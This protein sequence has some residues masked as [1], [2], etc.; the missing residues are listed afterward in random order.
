MSAIIDT[1]DTALQRVM[2][3]MKMHIGDYCDLATTEEGYLVAKDTSMATIFRYEGFRSVVGTNEFEGLAHS[4]EEAMAPLFAKRGQQ[5]QIVFVRDTDP[6][7]E[8]ST[9]LQPSYETCDVL[10]LDLKDMLDDMKRVHRYYCLSEAVYIVAWT[11][12]AVVSKEERKVEN[13][14]LKEQAAIITGA[15]IGKIDHAQNPWLASKPL[16]EAHIS[17]VSTVQAIFD[18][19]G[20]SAYQLDAHQAI[21]T[22]KKF[23]YRDY[24][25]A[26]WR[27]TLFGDKVTIRWKKNNRPDDISCL[28]PP[29]L[30]HQILSF[31]G[32][33]GNRQ[34]Q[35]GLT[36]T[37]AV[38]L[39]DK[40]Y[41]PVM[42]STHPQRIRSFTHIFNS[43]NNA[44]C[45][46]HL[47][48]KPM[49]WAI[50]FSIEA[51]G[52]SVMGMKGL[53]SAIFQGFNKENNGALNKASKALTDYRRD[54]GCVVKYQVMAMTWANQDQHDDLTIRRGKLIK[55]LSGWGEC[56]VMEQTGDPLNAITCI[57]PGLQLKSIAPAAAAPLED[58]VKMLPI[59]RPA[60]PFLR[61]GQTIFRS[62]DGKVMNYEM[63]SDLQTAWVTLVFAVMGSGKSV[64]LNRLNIEQVL[65]GGNTRLPFI[66]AVDIG[67]SSKGFITTIQSGLPDRQKHLAIYKRIQN[68]RDYCI[69]QLETKLGMRRPLSHEKAVML[70]FILQLVRNPE[71]SN[72]HEYMQA[73]ASA[74]IDAAF[75]LKSDDN[76][77]GQPD[78]YSHGFNKTVTAAIEEA[79]IEF[80]PEV[81]TW[82]EIQDKLFDAG[83]VEAAEVAKRYACPT[84]ETLIAVA[85]D[86]MIRE[87]YAKAI[88]GGIPVYEAFTISLRSA[89]QQFPAFAF[90]TN[91]D[92][93]NARLMAIDL[94]DVAKAGGAVERKATALFYAYARN[95]F[96]RKINLSSEDLQYIPERYRNYYGRI[97]SELKEDKKRICYD[98]FHKTAGMQNFRDIITADGREG[99]KWNLE[100]ILASQLPDDFLGMDEIATAKIILSAGTPKTR[101]KIRDIFGLTKTEENAL[102]AFCNGPTPA[103]ATFLAKLS[104][105]DGE[106]TQLFTSTLPPSMYWAL[107]TGAEDRALRDALERRMPPSHARR[108]LSRR[109][110]AGGCKAYINKLANQSRSELDEQLGDNHQN[111]ILA[112]K[113]ADEIEQDYRQLVE[114]GNFYRM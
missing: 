19:I 56:T 41:A 46:T 25:P 44:S 68:T 113:L 67:V 24:V 21:T 97:E 93:G 82:W 20:A 84:L 105:K 72:G 5:L 111:E 100:I 59:A 80:I 99:R 27:P 15:G 79:Q 94:Q 22:Q 57:T 98:E 32:L 62:A 1:I 33:I 12:P 54:G 34:G 18:R 9:V 106:Y 66:C 58:V 4:L 76:P 26:T 28:L 6:E 10:Q 42:I 47:G 45:E 69:N 50:S 81:T 3:S 14:H 101:T 70:S 16:K 60:S 112:E 65:R 51:D 77:Q 11:R 71:S 89:I 102:V 78:P 92:I 91:F 110:P 86:K 108:M 85:S 104:M 29:P 64:W 13:K 31:E 35:G 87:Q 38:R 17:F 103:G 88:D 23:L 39:G 61:G 52:M 63:F 8:L 109:F 90:H 75:E 114:S 49:P 96:M 36:D 95:I 30:D 40:I 7:D 2:S 83:Y 53:F 73:F 43:M 37:R 48:I 55:L 74:V 107:A